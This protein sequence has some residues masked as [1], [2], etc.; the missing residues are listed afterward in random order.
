MENT[1]VEFRDTNATMLL[2]LPKPV[3]RARAYIVEQDRIAIEFECGEHTYR[4]ECSDV[5]ARDFARMIQ[6]TVAQL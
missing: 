1:Y 2:P 6:D 5:D 4:I 3:V